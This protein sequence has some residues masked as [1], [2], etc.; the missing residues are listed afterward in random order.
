MIILIVVFF[1]VSVFGYSS[2][3]EEKL[4]YNEGYFGTVFL[5]QAYLNIGM[6]SDLWVKNIYTPKNAKVILRTIKNFLTSSEKNLKELS[7]FSI[8]LSDRN[9]LLQ[10]MDISKD[11]N[12]EVGFM[13]IYMDSR[14]KKDLEQYEKFRKQSW[15]K[16]KSLMGLKK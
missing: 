5:Y 11:L 9:T 7:D 3:L 12:K 8:S 15:S 16:L 13:L 6:A 10:L 4:F 2:K 14:L 1:S